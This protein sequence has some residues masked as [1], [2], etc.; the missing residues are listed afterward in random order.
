MLSMPMLFHFLETAR[1]SFLARKL[2][3]AV[4][5]LGLAL[6]FTCF[7][8]AYVFVH[9]VENADQ[10]FP[11]ADRIHVV[12]QASYI[13][14]L[15]LNLPAMERSSSLVEERLRI[16]LPDLEAVARATPTD[17]V[18]VS[19]GENRSFR[20]VQYAQPS[21]LDIFGFDFLYGAKVST[22]EHVRSAILT[23]QVALEMFGRAD[24][25]GELIELPDG[26]SIEIAG[27]ISAIQNPSHL[28]DAIFSEG[29]EILVVSVVPEDT[30]GP[31]QTFFGEQGQWLF[32][33]IVTYVLLPA[34]RRVTIEEFNQYLAGLGS[35]LVDPADGRVDLDARPVSRIAAEAVD[36]L[37]WDDYPIS[38]TG[39]IL[40]LGATVLGIAVANFINL[41]IAAV[42]LRTREVAVRKI[43]GASKTQVVVQ[44]LIEATVTAAFALCLA[45]AIVGL[46]L[47]AIGAVTQQVFSIPW[48]SGFGWLVLSVVA[49][50]GLMV[51]AYPALLLSQVRPTQALRA[52]GSRAGSQIFGTILITAQFTAASSLG[53]FMLVVQQQNAEFRE[54][55]LQ[56]AEDPIVVLADTPSDVGV[57][58]EVLRA[59]LLRSPEIL[60]VTGASSLPWEAMVG[61]TGYSRSPDTAVE[62]VFTQQRRVTFDYFDVL[63]LHLSA[64]MPF[65]VQQQARL[66]AGSDSGETQRR[67]VLDPAAVEQFGWSNPSNAVGQLLYASARSASEPR[68][69]VEVIGVVR[70]APF[71]FLGWGFDAF[72][73]ELIPS[74]NAYPIIRIARDGVGPAVSHIDSVWQELVPHSPIRREFVNDRF[75]QM[76]GFFE[77]VNRVFV[78]VAGLGLGVAAM[79]LFG[80]AAFVTGRRQREVGIRKSM[81]ATATQIALVLLRDFS[82]P[83]IVANI[84]AWP[85][86]FMAAT[87]YLNT[88]VQRAELGPEPFL[89]S[90]GLTLVVAFVAVASH[91]V[92]AAKTQP[93]RVLRHE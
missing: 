68:I 24:V 35:R 41:A 91:V 73:Y 10:H 26:Q 50:C 80:I 82:K 31:E 87:A 45:L 8:G 17:E 6:G 53:I 36:G 52:S 5:V 16:D 37:F 42:T 88:F 66:D 1:R 32:P 93:A 83:V 34:D 7:I 69:P 20:R 86:G 85:L 55:G 25:A 78:A 15:A 74:N 47:P 79:G 81:G 90:L 89:A 43:V 29:F 22:T 92:T 58:A 72:A 64:G 61:G 33:S 67:V 23:E 84:L 71:E 48:S 65:T 9:Y 56:F 39:V 19:N 28:G 70:R 12:F 27:V 63:G 49:V 51:G 62:A 59:A 13:E 30:G 75:Q 11:N 77:T 4:N 57:D 18:V 54:A 46:A 21:F 38:V 2:H 76:Y 14:S 44:Y 60:D 3:T 40:L